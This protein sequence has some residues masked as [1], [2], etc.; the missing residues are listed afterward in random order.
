[1]ALLNGYFLTYGLLKTMNYLEEAFLVKAMAV[2]MGICEV[3]LYGHIF[4]SKILGNLFSM[5]FKF[6]AGDVVY[7]ETKQIAMQIKNLSTLSILRYMLSVELITHYLLYW[8]ETIG[9]LSA[10]FILLCKND[11]SHSRKQSWFDRTFAIPL[12]LVESLAPFLA[13]IGVWIKIMW[14]DFM[15]TGDPWTFGQWL[16]FMGFVNQIAGLR[17]LQVVEISTIQHFVFSGSNAS[18]DTEELLLLDDWWNITLLSAVSNLQLNWFDNMVF[19]YSLDPAMTELLLKNHVVPET[20]D[21]QKFSVLR[22]A[23]ESDIILEDYDAKIFKMLKNEKMGGV[24]L[25][26]AQGEQ[27]LRYVGELSASQQRQK[28]LAKRQ[29][30]EKK[31]KELRRLQKKLRSATNKYNDA[32]NGTMPQERHDRKKDD[33]HFMKEMNSILAAYVTMDD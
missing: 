23:K 32:V 11:E 4:I 21:G 7:L 10:S 18:L 1:M 12:Y 15:F 2:L 8:Q 27:M 22:T 28:T 25:E 16:I 20:K 5:F 24:P 6:R 19:W 33:I 31:A 14:L 9:R 3:Y 17:V 13:V 29:K 30:N 26:V